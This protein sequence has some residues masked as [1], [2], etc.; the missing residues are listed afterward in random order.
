MGVKL[1]V[2]Y[3]EKNRLKMFENRVLK[4]IF[5]PKKGEVAGQWRRE[6]DEEVHNF[7]T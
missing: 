1:G 7:H 4:I 2:S 3:I 6:Y 5:G